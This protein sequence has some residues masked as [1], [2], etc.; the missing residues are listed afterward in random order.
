MNHTNEPYASDMSA[1]EAEVAIDEGYR[2][3]V[4][5]CSEGKLTIGYGYNITAGMP[6]DEALVLMRYR[7]EKLAAQL[8]NKLAWFGGITPA[9]QRALLN[10]AYQLGINGL[11][12]FKNMLGCAAV[13]NWTGAAREALDSKWAVQTPARA[14]RIANILGKG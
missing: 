10:M 2:S 8:D 3:E 9:R 11:L 6:Q 12:N 14:K 5:R 4:Y 1:L 13:G 7:L